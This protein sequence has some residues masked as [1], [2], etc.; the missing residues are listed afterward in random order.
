MRPEG[1]RGYESSLEWWEFTLPG[2]SRAT[3]WV[4]IYV[5]Y[6]SPEA[7]GERVLL[8][9]VLRSFPDLPGSIASV[10]PMESSWDVRLA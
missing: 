8:Y 7:M 2:I 5:H 10:S 1:E 3:K 6:P 9:A 4:S